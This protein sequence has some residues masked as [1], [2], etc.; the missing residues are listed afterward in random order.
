MSGGLGASVGLL[1]D[2]SGATTASGAIDADIT[3]GLGLTYGL[4]VIRAQPVTATSG[5]GISPALSAFYGAVVTERIAL[6]LAQSGT[7][8]YNLTAT[9]IAR[10]AATIHPGVP[11]LL[12]EGIG[13]ELTQQAQQVVQV[14]ETLGLQPVLAPMMIYGRTIAETLQ[15]ASVLGRFFG[16]E[17]SETFGISP[18]LTGVARKGG[19]LTETIGVA[20]GVTPQLVLRVT[21]ADTIDLDDTDAVQ[22]IFQPVITEG[23]DISAGYVAPDGSFTTWAINTRSGAV[24]EYENYAFNSFARFG[25]KYVGASDSGLYEL[26]GDDDAGADIVATIRSGFAQWAG[27]RLS[28]FKGAYLAIRGGGD[29]VLKVITGDGTTYN[30]AVNAQDMKTTKIRMGKGLRARYFAFELVS[31]GQDFDLDTLEFVPLVADRRV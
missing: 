16:G 26:L 29:F 14:L 23:V 31:T 19:I 2:T 4:S 1:G 20:E 10:V 22:M 7:F 28:S 15:V 18:A 12:A 21:V 6:A 3:V 25:D 13:V 11:V 27:T 30:Y 5:V 17:L 8:H 24:T 9:D